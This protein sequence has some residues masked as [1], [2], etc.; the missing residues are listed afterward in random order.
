VDASAIRG[1]SLCPLCLCVDSSPTRA[2][3]QPRYARSVENATGKIIGAAIEVHRALG[4]GLLESAYQECLCHELALRAIAFQRQLSLPV[5]YKGLKL[6]CSYRLDFLV[7]DV[8]VEIKSV[9]AIDPIHEAQ[10]LTYMKLGNW[11]LGLLIN[12]NVALLTRGI[13]RLIL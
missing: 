13:R 3:D 1:W 2:L 4:P 9:A 12:F 10:L 5:T 6:D 11:K 7:D 8:V